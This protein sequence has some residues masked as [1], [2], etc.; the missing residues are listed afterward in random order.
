MLYPRQPII[1]PKIGHFR[2]IN[3]WIFLDRTM[4]LLKNWIFSGE[5]F[6]IENLAKFLLFA[7]NFFGDK[8]WP[9]IKRNEIEFAYW[10]LLSR[11]GQIGKIIL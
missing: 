2:S 9:E 10:F 7:Q 3:D 5:K 6:F 11:P 8:I 1:S 4:Y